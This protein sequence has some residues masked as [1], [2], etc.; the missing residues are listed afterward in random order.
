MRSRSTSGHFRSAI[1]WAFPRTT[2]P[3]TQRRSNS[4]TMIRAA[5]LTRR[6]VAATT[7]LQQWH[8]S[9]ILHGKDQRAEAGMIFA[10]HAAGE[11]THCAPQC[12]TALMRIHLCGQMR[13][14]SI[15]AANTA[16]VALSTAALA[17]TPGTTKMPQRSTQQTT[18]ITSGTGQP[19][20][21]TGVASTKT[22]D[23]G[24]PRGSPRPSSARQRRVSKTTE[25]LQFHIVQHLPQLG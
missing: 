17:M 14:G 16:W 21:R 12:T 7:G 13:R 6:R 20:K 22:M 5:I 1:R 3:Q 15:V 11:T 18:S 10:V 23:A 2:Q 25:V 9:H 24:M 4:V 19:S 8:R